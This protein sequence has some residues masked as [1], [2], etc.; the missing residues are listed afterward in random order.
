M[1]DYSCRCGDVDGD[2]GY[3]V[4]ATWNTGTSHP[5]GG[6]CGYVAG[7][8]SRPDYVS[9]S[10][11]SRVGCKVR[12]RPR[13]NVFGTKTTEAIGSGTVQVLNKQST[14]ARYK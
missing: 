1:R 3:M 13:C 6:Q 7:T 11:A 8:V 12:A 9:S 2:A 10:S 4:P 14:S 5:V